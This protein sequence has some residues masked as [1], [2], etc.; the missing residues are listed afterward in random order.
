MNIFIIS[1]APKI[2]KKNSWRSIYFSNYF[3]S[4]A[5]AG[6]A[7]NPAGDC[8][9]SKSPLYVSSAAVVWILP[10]AMAW[11]SVKKEN[12]LQHM[13]TLYQLQIVIFTCQ[14]GI[15]PDEYRAILFISLF[16]LQ[17][18]ILKLIYPWKS[19]LFP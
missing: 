1:F 7:Q 9:I 18:H 2:K 8:I 19:F 5:T 16:I 10:V 12:T 14:V 17:W 3:C 4:S 6:A 13:F 11:E 15:W